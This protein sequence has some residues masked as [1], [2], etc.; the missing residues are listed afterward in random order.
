M[1]RAFRTYRPYKHVPNLP[2]YWGSII[3]RY[4]HRPWGRLTVT[5]GIG[6]LHTLRKGVLLEHTYIHSRRPPLDHSRE[7]PHVSRDPVSLAPPL[8]PTYPGRRNVYP[9]REAAGWGPAD[10]RPPADALSGRRHPVPRSRG[11][12]KGA[13]RSLRPKSPIGTENHPC[14]G[15]GCCYCCCN[16]A[17][18]HS[19]A[20]TKLRS[21]A[22]RT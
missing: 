14:D 6:P 13:Q 9:P 5:Y 11:G 15:H 19:C 22:S 18:H 10:R 1:G 2:I 8:P 17:L 4:A 16:H 12:C 20:I 21:A 3:A 7:R